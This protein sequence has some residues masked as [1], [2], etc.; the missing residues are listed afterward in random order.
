MYL[1]KNLGELHYYTFF[2]S[3]RQYRKVSLCKS[4]DGLCIVSAEPGTV[5]NASKYLV[6]SQATG[7]QVLWKWI[8]LF[9]TQ[10]NDVSLSV[11]LFGMVSDD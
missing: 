10:M 1:Y 8:T 2:Q 4:I 9:A 6:V 5:P 7:S 3:L 11:S